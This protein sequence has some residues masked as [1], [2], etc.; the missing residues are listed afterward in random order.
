MLW[1]DI[2]LKKIFVFYQRHKTNNEFPFLSQIPPS[3]LANFLFAGVLNEALL[4]EYSLRFCIQSLIEREHF[5][6]VWN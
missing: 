6:R 5:I 2:K 3:R 4:K 1:Q